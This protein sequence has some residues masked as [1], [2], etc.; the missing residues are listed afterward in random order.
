LNLH[1]KLH[2]ATRG[3]ATLDYWETR[4]K[5]GQGS[6]SDI[7]WQATGQ[8]MKKVSIARRHWVSKHSSGFCGTSKMMYR[9]KQRISNLCPRCNT[10]VED[11]T[12]VWQ[13]QDPRATAVWVQ[14]IANLKVWLQ[15]QCTDPGIIKVLCAKLLAWQC[16][17][18]EPIPVATVDGL[19][20]VV[21]KQ[22]EIGWQSLLEGRPAFGW[23]LLQDRYLQKISS[24]RSG[25]RWLTALIQK[26]WDIAWDMWDNRNK[27]LHDTENS[28]ARALQIQQIQD[29]FAFGTAGLPNEAQALFGGGIQAL[30][31]QQPAYQTAWLIRITAAR[32]RS[33]RRNERQNDTFNT[34]R[35]GMR[36]WLIRNAP[37]SDGG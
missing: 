13:C 14:S 37:T 36:R 19:Q 33:E 35:A 29:Q 31:H 3:Q 21:Q 24:R 23:R 2:T 16:G 30:L 28:A 34:E 26:L 6:Y 1:A 7:D 11:A 32:A 5:F 10:E 22:D 4:G 20:D 8:A 15:T 25:L 18:T 27:V 9:W 12:H 17:S